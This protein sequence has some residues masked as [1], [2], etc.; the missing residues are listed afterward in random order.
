MKEIK[1]T[2]PE[3]MLE[4]LYNESDLYCPEI[5]TYIFTYNDHGSIAYYTGITSEM[6]EELE[7]KSLEGGEYWG[8]YLGAG[9]YIIDSKAYLE[10]HGEE[11][12]DDLIYFIMSMLQYKYVKCGQ[13]FEE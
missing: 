4:T 2:S 7:R 11:A 5:E 10:D 9:G 1:F 12:N 8:A 13:G 3:Q 6:A